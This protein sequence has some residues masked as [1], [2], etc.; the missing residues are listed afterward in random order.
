MAKINQKE[1]KPKKKKCEIKLK[2]YI[3]KCGIVREMEMLLKRRIEEKKK[4][5]KGQNWK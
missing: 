4:Q 1:S 3:R 2:S 5:E